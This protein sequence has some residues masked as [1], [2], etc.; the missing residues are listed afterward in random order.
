VGKQPNADLVLVDGFDHVCC[1]RDIWA[2][3]LRAVRA[4]SIALL[5]KQLAHELR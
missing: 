1:W 2:Q 4:N 5:R 3:V